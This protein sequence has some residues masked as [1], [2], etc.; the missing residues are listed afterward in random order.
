MNTTV[1][2]NFRIV[3]YRGYKMYNYKIKTG[4]NLMIVH[5]YICRKPDILRC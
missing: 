3:I 4:F 5:F 1:F 2:V